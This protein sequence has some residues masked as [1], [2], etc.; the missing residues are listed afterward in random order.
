M[1]VLLDTNILLDVLE[2][3]MPHFSDS[4]KTFMKAAR[5]EIEAIIGA[6]SIT[7]I[8]YILKRNCKDAQRAL[9][10]IINMIQIVSPVDTKAI[11]IQEAIKYPAASSGVFRS[12]D[13]LDSGFNT[14]LTAASGGVL[15]PSPRIKLML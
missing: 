14:F 8:Y 5:N 13:E 4:Y 12:P 2:K 9:G 15:N 6:G 11:D 7:D 3:R 1:K 10:L